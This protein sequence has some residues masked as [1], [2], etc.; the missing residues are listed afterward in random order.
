MIQLRPYQDEAVEA[1]MAW[2]KK[3]SDPC[4]IEAVTAAGKSL[5]LAEIIRRING[6]SGKKVLCLAP[7]KELVEQNA[8]KYRALGESCSLFCDGLGEKSVRHAA[9]FGTPQ[10][11]NNAKAKFGNQIAAIVIDEAHFAITG[12][13]KR[14]VE[15][16]QGKNPNVR[17]IGTTATPF[18]TNNGYIFRHWPD[19]SANSDEVTIDPFFHT[20]VYRVTGHDLLDQGYI[21]PVVFGDH[22][23]G[24]ETGKLKRKSNGLWDEKIVNQVFVGQGRKTAGIVSDIVNKSRN[25]DG[26]M[27]FAATV[28][29][30][31]EIME[32]LPE[33]VSAIVTGETPR[34]ERERILADTKAKKIRYLVNVATLTTGVDITHIDVIAIMRATESPGLFLQIMGR[35]LRLDESKQDCLM[36]D[37]ADN[38]DRHFSGGDIFNPEIKARRK[39]ESNPMQVPCPLCGHVNQFGARKNEEGFEVDSEGYFADLSGER[40]EI[41][42]NVWYPAHYGRRCRG[43]VLSGGKHQQCTYK[44]SFKECHECG[45]ENDIAARYCTS[46]RAEIVDPNE[47]LQEIATSIPSDPYRLRIAAVNSIQVRRWPGRNGKPDTLRVDYYIDETPHTVSQWLSPRVSGQWFKFCESIFDRVPTGVDDAML[48]ES[49]TPKQVSFRKNSGTKY[50]DVVSTE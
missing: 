19:G 43:E 30:A 15:H 9:I 34:A 1:T 28:P 49:R 26:V 29:H 27:I 36:L 32:S 44:W 18:T 7:T 16:I 4:L 12:T 25:R 24:Y 14:I 48:M 50:F 35:G 31:Y 37:Y 20:C 8:D 21:T 2:I 17:V 13:V 39:P 22:A 10:S 6:A 23:D 3:C 40:I 33:S 46:C 41:A 45:Q 38:I 5:I 47:K 11:V 42:D